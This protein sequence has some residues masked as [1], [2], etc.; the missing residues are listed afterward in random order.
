MTF[1]PTDLNP[2]PAP[3]GRCHACYSTP[4]GPWCDNCDQWPCIC[5]AED[6]Q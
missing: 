2:W 1:E 6:A 5:A 4:F 3:G